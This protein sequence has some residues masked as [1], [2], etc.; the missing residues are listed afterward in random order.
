[1][2]LDQ[3]ATPTTHVE[4]RQII[5]GQQR[6]TTLQLFLAAFRDFCS[7]NA[8]EDLGK[9][10]LTFTLNTGMMANP[11]VVRI[12]AKPISYSKLMAISVPK[13][14]DHY[15]SEATLGCSYHR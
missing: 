6:L 14:G 9:E 10:C 8:C 3:K 5:D 4:R 2:V 11:A 1:M 12:P 7:A 15:R 13:D